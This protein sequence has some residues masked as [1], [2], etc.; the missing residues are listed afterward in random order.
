LLSASEF[1]VNKGGSYTSHIEVL[2][3]AG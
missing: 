1:L 2:E 3:I